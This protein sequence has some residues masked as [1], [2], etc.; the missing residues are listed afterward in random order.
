MEKIAQLEYGLDDRV[1]ELLKM[2]MTGKNHSKDLPE[3]AEL[4]FVAAVP[5]NGGEPKM[6]MFRCV[7]GKE[8]APT[9]QK[10]MMVP[11][12]VYKDLDK[13][14]MARKMFEQEAEFPEVSQEFLRQLLG[15]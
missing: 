9:D 15:R 3:N 1:I 5:D 7:T 14:P 8:N 13:E 6:L 11:F 10:V 4:R 2:V 12:E